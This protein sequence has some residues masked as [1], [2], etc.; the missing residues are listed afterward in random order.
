MSFR[1][2]LTDKEFAKLT[3]QMYYRKPLT[4][5]V[6]LFV[7]VYV[8]YIVINVP[9]NDINQILPLAILPIFVL[10]VLPMS[11]WQGAMRTYQNTPALSEEMHI[12][13]SSDKI[14]I[15]TVSKVVEHQRS[16]LRRV[17]NLSGAKV[18]VFGPGHLVPIPKRIL[19][20][21]ETSFLDSL[22][23]K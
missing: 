3:L 14:T 20:Q 5:L 17:L 23:K 19:S 6:L 22:Q 16:D 7:P 10:F 9:L 1:F 12:N 8:G 21:A 15:E 18:L 13:V 4:L 11:V 2:R